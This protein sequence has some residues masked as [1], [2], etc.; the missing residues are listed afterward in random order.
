[1]SDAIIFLISLVFVCLEQLAYVFV[2]QAFAAQ[3]R[4]PKMLWMGYGLLLIYNI[5]V[6]MT[7]TYTPIKLGSI[8]FTLIIFALYNFSATWYTVLF[9]TTFSYMLIYCIDN[10]VLQSA[11]LLTKKGGMELLIDYAWGT[12]LPLLSK[13]ICVCLAYCLKRF[14]GYRFYQSSKNWISW[15]ATLLL[16]AFTFGFIMYCFPLAEQYPAIAPVF[17]GGSI[18]LLLLSFL[19]IFLV[20]QLDRNQQMQQDNLIL[21]KQLELKTQNAQNLTE[22]YTAQRR[23]SHDFKSHIE[24]IRALATE[25]DDEAVCQYINQIQG[26][27]QP[28]LLVVRTGSNLVDAILNQK[29]A[30]AQRQGIVMD[31]SLSNLTGLPIQEMD[32]SVVLCNLLDNAIEACCQVEKNRNI[33]VRISWQED[34]LLLCIRNSVA[35]P[36]EIV[37]GRVLT[38][39]KDRLA[40]GYGLRNVDAV[41]ERY[42]ADRAIQCTQQ[43]FVFTAVIYNCVAK[44]NK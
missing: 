11:V 26:Q 42:Q 33:H 9:A 16:P 20:E 41:L 18:G 6:S 29:F 37:D 27:A 14:L 4:S 22:S 40:H 2:L 21:T 24:V 28:Y 23:L 38:T 31:F 10:I 7:V 13:L 19:Q 34:E 3:K 32:L 1:M 17:L 35:Q 5:M 25:S 44:Q 8:L 43:E 36:V 15:I 39:K 30:T 12:F